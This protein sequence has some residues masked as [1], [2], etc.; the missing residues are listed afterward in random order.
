MTT[1]VQSVAKFIVQRSTLPISNLKLQKLLYYVQGWNLGLHG[2][3]IFTAEIQA[4]VHGPVV[5]VVFDQYRHFRWNPIDVPQEALKLDVAVSGHIH[6]VLDAYGS[7]TATQLE[8]LS[9][10]ED[11]WKLARNGL[12]ANIPSRVA[13]SHESMKKYFG[14]LAK[15]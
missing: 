8:A 11:P 4:W 7:L 5:P 6:S 14:K 9:H 2:E 3:P 12:P 1:P 10:D 13:I 15:G